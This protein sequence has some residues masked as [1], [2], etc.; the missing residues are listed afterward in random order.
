M[1]AVFTPWDPSGSDAQNN[2][3]RIETTSVA[4]GLDAID[5]HLLLGL[6]HCH[7]VREK[8]AG[9]HWACPERMGFCLRFFLT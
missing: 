4:I 8:S 7:I 6:Q 2:W 5:S 9:N 1:V 3:V